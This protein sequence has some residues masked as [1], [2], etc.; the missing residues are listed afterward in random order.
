MRVLHLHFGKDGGAERFFV[1]LV[2]AFGRRGVEQR[3]VIR[4]DRGWREGIAP[5]GP[6]IENHYRRLSLSA[7]VLEWRVRRLCRT[8]RPDA[9]MA[10]MPRAARLMPQWSDAVKLTRLGDFP[11]NL[12]HFGNCDLLVGNLPGIGTKC[13]ALGWTKPVVTISNFPRPVAPLPVSRAVHDTPDDVFLIAAGGRFVPR[14]GMDLAIRA[15]A[16][17]PGSWLWLAGDGKEREALEALVRDCRMTDR[18]RFLGWQDEPIHQI[19]AADA[20]VMPSRHEPLGN[21]LLEAWQAGVPSVSTASEG[22]S[23]FM[24]DGTDGLVVPIDDV[25]ALAAALERLRT[26]REAAGRFAEN[27]KSRLQEMFSEQGVVDAY[28]KLFSGDF[29]DPFGEAA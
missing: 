1:N 12:K 3:F 19:A 28:L 25:D 5:H 14:K 22:P 9:I 8:W 4:P 15:A 27:A 18:T 26:D 17:V 10:W 23:W 21:M 20:F 11:E 24:R 29:S 6:I 2:A 16:R 13:R 7:P